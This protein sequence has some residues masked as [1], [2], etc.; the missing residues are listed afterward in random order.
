MYVGCSGGVVGSAR[1][2][3]HLK[4][5]FLVNRVGSCRSRNHLEK[6]IAM[7]VVHVIAGVLV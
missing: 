1:R 4:R 5:W 2:L 7:S 6:G 3:I